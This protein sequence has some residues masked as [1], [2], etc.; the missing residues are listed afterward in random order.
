[1][2][3]GM[4]LSSGESRVMGENEIGRDNLG[5]YLLTF[6]GDGGKQKVVVG[7]GAVEPLTLSGDQKQVTVADRKGT[8]ITSGNQHL[9][10]ID[11]DKGTLF[12]F[13][14]GISEEETLLV[15]ESLLPIDVR[16]M[17]ARVGTS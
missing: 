9:I 12:V 7:G 8:L 15:A 16:D 13:G 6:S 11:S 1:M 14:G 17:R 2:P 5:F 4:A 3:E 10:L